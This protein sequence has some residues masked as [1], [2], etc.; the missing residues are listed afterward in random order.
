[1]LAEGRKATECVDVPDNAYADGLIAEAGVDNIR[2][3]AKSDKPFFLAVGFKKPHAPY[4][5]PKKYW[6]L[7]DRE[8]FPLAEFQD[9]SSDP[10]LYAYHTS[11]A[12]KRPKRWLVIWRQNTRISAAWR[13]NAM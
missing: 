13:N 4:V 6:D 10:V 3:M 5:A 12:L 9:M 11:T 8:K 2:K 7:Y 1:M